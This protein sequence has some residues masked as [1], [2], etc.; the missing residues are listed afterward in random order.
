MIW[1]FP[2][3]RLFWSSAELKTVS[4]W[5]YEFGY[6]EDF[7]FLWVVP[8]IFPIRIFV[9]DLCRN[10]LTINFWA[11]S[12]PPN[13]YFLIIRIAISIDSR[14]PNIFMPKWSLNH[15]GLI[16]VGAKGVIRSK[17]DKKVILYCF[18]MIKRYNY[19]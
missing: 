13:L 7:M 9:K 12:F 10:L 4:F 2:S 19:I 18:R 3:K 14:M 6:H 5:N 17:N 16:F 8:R 11:H 15:F 1:I